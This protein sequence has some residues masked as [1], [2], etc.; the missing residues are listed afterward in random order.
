LYLDRDYPGGINSIA[1]GVWADTG[2]V[3]NIQALS[4]QVAT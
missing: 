3:A 4:S 2:K 1:V